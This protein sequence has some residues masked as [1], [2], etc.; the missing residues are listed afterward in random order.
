VHY[1]RSYRFPF[2]SPHWFANVGFAT[3]CI[4]S[5]GVIPLIGQMLA[6][7][8]LFEVVEAMHRQ[9]DDRSYPDFSW[10]RFVPYLVRGAQVVL[11]Q[12]LASLPCTFVLTVAFAG[13]FIFALAGSGAEPDL[14]MLGVV[15]GVLILAS[16]LAGLLMFVVLVPLTLRVGLSQDLSATWS[17]SFIK[18]YVSRMWW[19]TMLVALFVLF[20]STVV[21]LAGL[22]VC[23]VGYYA[24]AALP[25]F[26]QYHLY[27]QLY[28]MYLARGGMPIR[29]KEEEPP[30]L[31]S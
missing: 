15:I 29:L 18:D 9:G 14:V 11:V 20:S 1:L 24:V 6:I 7:G 8:Y 25:M 27:Y 4:I 21:M 26:A 16:L 10:E 28:E 2:D 17:L 5:T 31:N 30:P 12:F 19:P 23:C 3:L 22:A 13:G